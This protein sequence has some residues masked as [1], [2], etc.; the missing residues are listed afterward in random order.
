MD[1][2]LQKGGNEYKIDPETNEIVA[3]EFIKPYS[4]L[5]QKY[6]IK[7]KAGLGK[8]AK[9]HTQ[10]NVNLY[11]NYYANNFIERP[12]RWQICMNSIKAWLFLNL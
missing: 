4:Y 5:N 12:Y 8:D 6:E 9:V 3:S 1:R 2:A 7:E 11:Y 10:F